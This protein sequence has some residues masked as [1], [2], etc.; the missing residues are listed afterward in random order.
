MFPLWLIVA[1]PLFGFAAN[2]LVSLLSARN[3]K[4]PS[5]GLSGFVAVAAC[6]LSFITVIIAMGHMGPTSSLLWRGWEWLPLP[7]GS[8]SL[9][10]AFDRLTAVMLLFITGIGTLI[11]LYSIGY[12]GKDRGFARFMAYLNLFMASMIVLVLGASLPVTFLGWEG[13]GLCSYLLIGFWKDEAANGDAA[14]KAFIFNRIGDLGFLLGAFFLYTAMGTHGSLDYNAISDF[15]AS[16]QGLALSGS[17]LVVAAAAFIFLGCT[18]KSAQLPL[19]TWLPDAMAGPTPVSALFHAATM[20]TSGVY[21]CARL[22][23]LFVL[24]AWVMPVIAVIGCAT[25]LYGAIAGLVQWDIKKVL[26][27]S[28]VSQLGFMFMAV[29]VGAFD[30]ALFHVFTHAFFKAT[31]FL[32]AGSVINALHHEQDMRRMGGLAKALPITYSAMFFGWFAIIG[33]PLG[34]GFMSKDLIIE[35]VMHGHIE[36][37]GVDIGMIIFLL[38]I[39]AALLTAVYMSRMMFLTF[40]SPSRVPAAVKA[41]IKEQ[42]FIMSAPVLFL[43]FGAMAAGCVW[44]DLVPN[45]NLFGTYL[46]PILGQAQGLLHAP[47]EAGAETAS[48]AP[49]YLA[50]FSS[51]ILAPIGIAIAWLFYRRGPRDLEVKPLQ[52]FAHTWTHGI[53]AVY[54]AVIVAPVRGI[55][56]ILARVVDQ[57]VIGGVVRSVGSIAGFLGEG[58]AAIQ[59]GRLRVS[60]LLSLAGAMILIMYLMAPLFA[61]MLGKGA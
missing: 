57:V 21:L 45:L 15:F 52:G 27:Y 18:G 4:G 8:L 44:F 28:T 43:G 1:F 9:D 38:A 35:R 50:I 59:R 60:V 13:V 29:G 40:W 31:L 20:V 37:G 16:P 33:L 32:G 48:N 10:F 53:D 22:A 2:G 5:T 39:L 51:V 19:L 24:S 47:V 11:H 26:A 41:H 25:A 12:M 36:F 42:P 3:A 14:R 56:W 49:I 23:D 46:N 55:A 54:G 7:H 6:A 58:Y 61:P 34:S 17:G 30:V